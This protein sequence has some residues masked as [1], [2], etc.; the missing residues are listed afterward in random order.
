VPTYAAH[1]QITVRLPNGHAMTP[2]DDAPVH[3]ATAK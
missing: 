3:A 2:T 1:Q